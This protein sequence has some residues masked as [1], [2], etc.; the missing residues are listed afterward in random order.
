MTVTNLKENNQ[1]VTILEGNIADIIQREIREAKGL[2]GFR[3]E[4]KVCPP[5]QPSRLP[6]IPDIPQ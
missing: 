1:L 2:K 5:S 3:V 4:G 6:I